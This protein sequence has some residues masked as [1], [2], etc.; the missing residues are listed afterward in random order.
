MEQYED[1]PSFS[2]FSAE[3]KWFMDNG[4]IYTRLSIS[5]QWSVIQ[6]SSRIIQPLLFPSGYWWRV[7]KCGL[8]EHGRLSE[9]SVSCL[10]DLPGSSTVWKIVF[11]VP[12]ELVPLLWKTFHGLFMQLLNGTVHN[13]YLEHQHL[14]G[15]QCAYNWSKYL[16]PI[17]SEVHLGPHERFLNW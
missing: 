13:L 5:R 10:T 4:V 12:T 7:D 6:L 14:F 2:S 16:G 8:N 3:K 1:N 15:C 17:I 9:L 11:G